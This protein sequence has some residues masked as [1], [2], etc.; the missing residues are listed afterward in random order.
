MAFSPLAC[1]MLVG[2]GYSSRARKRKAAQAAREA[3]AARHQAASTAV[4]SA[5]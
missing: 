3:A 2:Y 1:S 4:E 5:E